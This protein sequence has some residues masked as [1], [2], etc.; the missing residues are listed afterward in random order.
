M[1]VRIKYELNGVYDCGMNPYRGAVIEVPQL[2]KKVFTQENASKKWENVTLGWHNLLWDGKEV[3]SV[4][5]DM[6]AN[7]IILDVAELHWHLCPKCHLGYEGEPVFS[8]K[9]NKTEICPLCYGREIVDNIID[10]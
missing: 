6:S 7:E 1:E 10:A 5:Y 3:K 9:D 8:R 4:S 2:V